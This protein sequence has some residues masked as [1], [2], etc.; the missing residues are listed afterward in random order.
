LKPPIR[1]PRAFSPRPFLFILA[2]LLFLGLTFVQDIVFLH[3]IDGALLFVSGLGVIVLLI[4]HLTEHRR[5]EIKAL[6]DSLPVRRLSRSLFL[7]SFLVYGLYATGL[8]FPALPFTGDEPHYL[9][10]SRSLV[11]D[12]DINL[13]E[14]Y[15][16]REYKDFYDGEL[17]LHAYPGRK[18]ERYLYSKHL[19]ALP[20]LIAPFYLVAE[21]AARPLSALTLSD[22]DERA[23][24][25]FFSRLPICLLA[26]LLGL[27]F[28]LSAWE[29]TQKKGAALLAWLIFSF[30]SP[31][32]F[33][34]HLIYPEIP[35]ALIL[36]A[37]AYGLILKKRIS[38]QSLLWTGAGIGLLPWFGIKYLP[39]AGAALLIIVYLAARTG[40][41]EAKTAAAFLSPLA[42]SAG[43]FLLFL[44]RLYG[45]I[46]PQSVYL[47]SAR[48]AGSPLSHFLVQGPTEFLSRFLGFLFDQRIG[49]FIY[50]PILILGLAGFYFLRKRRPEPAWL[51]GGL[52]LIFWIFCSGAIYWGGFCP[53]GRPLLPVA[54]IPALF[55]ALA[56]ANERNKAAV[57]IRKGLIVLSFFLVFMAFPKPRLLYQ[58]SMAFLLGPGNS[59]L[60]NR[61]LSSLSGLLFDW[62][63]WIPTLATTAPEQ[64]T[65]G[66]AF[67]WIFA[68]FAITLIFL[69]QGRRAESAD[70]S[71]LGLKG[72]LGL[73][74]ILGLIFVTLTFFNVRLENSFALGAGM[75]FPQDENSFGPE[76]GGFWV[77]GESRTTL[78][79]RTDTPFSKM[80]VRLQS[81]VEGKATVQL[82]NRK[83]KWKRPARNMPEKEL[84]FFSPKPFRWKDGYLY[85]LQVSEKGGFYPFNIDLNSRDKRFLGVFVRLDPNYDDTKLN[86][87][88]VSL[89]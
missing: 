16:N 40:K 57:V 8:V 88:F 1:T 18:G 51:L 15:G 6:L 45:G 56:L 22:G 35:V 38:A 4:A 58:D 70:R 23:V 7:I 59:E 44:S 83:Q 42:V 12:G 5:G 52:F 41:I 63:K 86:S 28:F 75:A 76:L 39:L 19:P 25:I 21:K 72:H 84:V 53:P 74:I 68:V 36:A 46:S 13:A 32:L 30:S 73:V 9:L 49:L 64:R 82:G 14:D 29:L 24:I 34:S 54:W 81:P 2:P 67:L 48:G 33:Y 10:I 37:I 61:L 80:S 89:R 87:L 3:E 78:I 27:V 79:I 31:L 62:T 77:R 11:T 71:R 85:T 69:R 66:I 26:S 55:L 17:D 50:A 20:A 47:G 43:V 65:W 60:P